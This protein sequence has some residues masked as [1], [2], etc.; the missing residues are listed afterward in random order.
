MYKRQ[1]DESQFEFEPLRE[2][3]TEAAQQYIDWMK[4]ID[5]HRKQVQISANDLE[6]PHDGFREGQRKMAAAV[7]VTA[8]D[9]GSLLCEAPTGIGKTISTLFPAMKAI[10]EKHIQSVAYLTAKNSGRVAANESILNLQNNGLVVS[11]ITITAKKT[12]CHCSNGSCERNAD[13][14]CPLT[15]GFFDRLPAARQE[16]MTVGV[17]TPDIIDEFAHRYQLCPFE[18]T[19]QMLPWVTLVICDYNYIFDPLVRLTHFTE[20]AKQYLLLIDE[21]HNLVDRA[22]SMLS[23][24]HI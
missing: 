12:S 18:L 22:R 23:L 19:L 11:A 10:G 4:L 20:N 3:F 8:R 6:F 21:A 2:F 5:A 24:I 1:I 9:K 17:I 14:R 7:Y 13:G 16:L 15:L